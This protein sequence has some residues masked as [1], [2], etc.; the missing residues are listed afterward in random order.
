MEEKEKNKTRLQG[1]ENGRWKKFNKDKT[2][3]QVSK[4]LGTKSKQNI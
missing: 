1:K 4:W 3:K 2:R